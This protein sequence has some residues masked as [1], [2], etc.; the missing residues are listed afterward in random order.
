MTSSKH[1]AHMERARRGDSR[2]P[3]RM[4]MT[5]LSISPSQ[6]WHFLFLPATSTHMR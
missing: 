2:S 1:D 5:P 4:N 3:E 6:R